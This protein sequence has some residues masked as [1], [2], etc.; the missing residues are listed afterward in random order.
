MISAAAAQRLRDYF[1]LA[2]LDGL[3][4][5]SPAETGAAALVVFYIERTQRGA[6]PALS[7]PTLMR[8]D[9]HMEI[10]A[11]TRANL[12]LTQTLSGRRDGALLAAIDRTV[13]PGGGRC[14]PNGSP[15]R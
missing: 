3:G 5:L 2:T 11:A 8:F 9:A 6:R 15:G 10:D 7:P 13:T 12:E 1:G 4:N 14:W